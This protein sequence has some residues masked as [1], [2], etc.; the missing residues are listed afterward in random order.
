MAVAQARS[1]NEMTVLVLDGHS[2]AALETVQ[3]LGRAGVQ[4]D[5]AAEN[6][7][8]LAMHSRYVACRLLQPSQTH[9]GDFHAWLRLQDKQRNYALIVPATEASLLGVR[10]LEEKDP[11]RLKTV[12]PSNNSLD[13]ALDKEKTW[14]LARELGVPVPASDLILSVAEIG[15]VKQFPVV[16]KPTH[17]KVTIAGEL[18]TLAVAVVKNEAER[19]EQLRRWLP[20]TPVQQQQY[21]FGCGVGVELLFSRG[22]KVWHFAHKRMHEYPLTGGASSYRRS[23]IPPPD[24]LRDAEKLLTALKWHG[25]AMIEFKMDAQGR[26]WLMEINPRLWGSVALSLDA[27][28]NFP[29]GLLQVARGEQPV[30]QPLYKSNYYTRD[31]RTDVDWLK[32]NLRANSQDPL[33]HT[34]AR[35]HSFLELLRPLTG[36][37][38][39]DHFDWH[40][41]GIARRI[42]TLAITDQLRPVYGKARGWQMKRRLVRHHRSLL[43]RLE[44]KGGPSKIV[45]VCYGNICRSPLAAKLAEQSLTGVAIESA[46]FHEQAGRSSPEKIVRIGNALGVKLAGH[47]SM[48]VTRD[49]LLQADLVVAMDLENLRCIQQEFPEILDRTTLLGLFKTP[50]IFSIADPYL[51]DEAAAKEICQQVHAGVKGLAAWIANIR[52]ATKTSEVSSAALS[53]R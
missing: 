22:Q 6:K 49:S 28:V 50:P 34:R 25:V 27:G 43:Q 26:Y 9:A 36:R 8:C 38:S 46:G 51:I 45:F 20:L 1:M 42:L 3:S 4:V 23:I 37:E 41:L 19:Q 47:R 2:R 11:L 15:H 24:M 29:L 33:L 32:C 5:V 21:V 31:L 10:L 14:Q 18:R 16:L 52:M 40:D 30:S 35:A 7:D 39:W 12:I 13:V 44:A 53:T 48:R 17:S